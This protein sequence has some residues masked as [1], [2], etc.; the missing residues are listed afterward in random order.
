MRITI[1]N[2][3]K[4]NNLKL[5]RYP[6]Q[7]MGKISIDRIKYYAGKKDIQIIPDNFEDFIIFIASLCNENNITIDDLKE[8]VR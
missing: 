7:D 6:N 1:D 8:Y 5:E 2:I 3:T 4:F